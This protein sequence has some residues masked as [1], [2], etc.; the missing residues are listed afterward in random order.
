MKKLLKIAKRELYYYEGTKRILGVHSK[1]TGNISSG[2]YGNISSGLTGD[3]SGLT[4]DISGLYGN[5][6]ELIGD[7]SSGLTGDISSGLYG[8]IDLCEITEEEREKG[9]KI[10]DLVEELKEEN[11]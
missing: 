3:I 7:I 9:I 1:I 5:I 4:G 10:S 8:N 6:S 11:K 2:L